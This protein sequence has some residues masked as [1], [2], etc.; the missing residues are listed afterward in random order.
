MFRRTIS[1]AFIAIIFSSILFAQDTELTYPPEFDEPF[2]LFSK[3]LGEF[4][5]PISSDNELSQQYFNQ[6]FQMMYAFTKEDAARSFREAQKADQ[7]CAICY[8]GEAWAWGSYLNGPMRK[9][10]A[11]R[12]YAA[13]QKAVELA[14]EGYANENEK[15]FIEAMSVRYVEDFKPEIRSVQDSAYSKAMQE[16]HRAFP[17]DLDAATFYAES[18]FLLEPRRGN[19]DINDPDVQQLHQVLEEILEKDIKHPGACHLYIHATESTTDPGKAE[20]C[21]EFIGTSIPGASHINHMPSHTFAEI[22]RWGDAVRANIMAWHSDQKASVGEG[23]AIYPSHNLHML[24]FAAS[25]DGQSG[26]ATQAGRDY[27]KLTGNNVYEVLTLI[28]FG[29]FDEVLRVSERPTHAVHAGM[30]DFSMGYARLKDGDS[31]M[32]D[33]YL[34]KVLAAADTSEARF[35]FHSAE[36]LLGTVGGIL[37][38]EIHL[39]KGDTLAAIASFE[40]ATMIED[41]LDYDEPE[42]LPFAARHWLG[43]ALLSID[44]YEEAEAVY[45]AELIDHPNNGWSYFGLLKALEGQGKTDEELETAFKE[46]WARSDTWIRSSKF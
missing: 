9:D 23:F 2:P 24:A 29:R 32:A 10:E 6:G 36:K 43:S 39:A 17:E 28:R 44:K 14:D 20:A 26:V 4:E 22:G 30:W 3:A 19:R 34:E 7:N 21:A 25:M 37:E 35:R 27:T 33:N 11:P 38:G 8:W 12:A 16:V 31:R 45:R 15:A 18:L 46:S 5:R 42:P 40:R 13:I 41:S 1:V